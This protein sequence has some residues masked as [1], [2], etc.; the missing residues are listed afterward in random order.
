MGDGDFVKEV[1][2]Q[3]NEQLQNKYRIQAE[4]YD[5]NTLVDRV[6]EITELNSKEILDAEKDRKRIR[7]RSIL[8]FSATNHLGV[9]QT[10]LG[11]ILN[12]TQSAISHAVQ[13][14]RALEEAKSYSILND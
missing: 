3:A 12:L 10:E 13:R 7:A 2:S 1:L 11:R 6:A 9:S 5:L 8:C 4:G 14:G